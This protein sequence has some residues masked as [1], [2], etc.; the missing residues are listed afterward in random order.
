[1]RDNAI[2]HILIVS[3]YATVAPHFET[4]L[5]I[6][7]RHLDA[8]D[9]VEW[10]A[11]FGRLTNCDFNP[12]RT[13]GTCR[14]C[15]L[16]RNHGLSFLSKPITARHLEQQTCD[17]S[18]ILQIESVEELKAYREGGFDIGYAVLSS[19]VS[20]IRDPEPIL[21][22]HSTLISALYHSAMSVYLS[23]CQYLRE[24]RVDCVYVFNGRFAAMRGV[25]RACQQHSVECYIHERGATIEKYE[26][27][28]NHLPHEMGPIQ[29]LIRQAWATAP[30]PRLRDS[31]AREWFENR[32]AGVEKNWMS[33]T[34]DQDAERLPDNWDGARR[35]V[36][37]FSSSDDE[38]VAIGDAWQHTLFPNQ[39][40]GVEWICAELQQTAPA[41]RVYLRMHP[42]LKK[43]ENEMK[44]RML[45]LSHPNLT[46]I[47][48]DDPV[49][50]Y[51]LMAAADT[52][53]TFGSSIGI[54][55]VY[56]GKPSVLLGP[57]LYRELGGTYQPQTPAEVLDLLS[58]PLETQDN[59]G[60]QAYAY[61]FNTHGMH[62]IHLN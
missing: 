23:V 36:V 20:V 29:N 27:Y 60:A 57:C 62:L 56:W 58:R 15:V 5:E 49:N 8:G 55:A 37:I 31:L 38:F 41:T 51:R 45:K 28:Q 13:E 21:K 16:R 52:V 2:R 25:F 24:N 4:E 59:R 10:L 11:C 35:N 7:Q 14:D 47:A 54:E 6:A 3:P 48:P 9:Q 33:F 61:W 32:R 46:V 43:V 18:T 39:L 34:K 44:R 42:N 12:Q 53:T 40:E 22:D 19:L 50:T 17:D 30:E 26:L 1:M